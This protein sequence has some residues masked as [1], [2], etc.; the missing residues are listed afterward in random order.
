[1]SVLLPAARA[2]V[3]A[4]QSA[5][6]GAVRADVPVVPDDDEARG[7][8]EEELARTV[9]Q[10]AQPS[11]LDRIRDAIG[12][13]LADVL[14]DFQGLDANLGVVLIVFGAAVV[15]AVAVWLVKPR[16]NPGRKQASAALFDDDVTRTAE[17]HRGLARQ[18][19]RQ[20]R[21]D[22]ALAEQFRAIIRSA[23]ERTVIDPQPG[24]TA[25]EVAAKLCLAFSAEEAA[26]RWLARRFNEVHYGGATAQ[27]PDFTA[28]VELDNRLMQA[29]PV[30]G[31]P[32]TGLA[33][34][35]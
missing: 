5:V 4:A 20:G 27:E 33:V 30:P 22:L 31:G 18:A 9:Y 2:A 16:L 7:W 3:H 12:Q 34:P 24:Q 10:Q 26:L 29:K 32:A 8:V 19:A 35:R 13:W 15:I 25:E 11:L 14:S 21:W 28:A 6:P 17:E 23:E 1:M